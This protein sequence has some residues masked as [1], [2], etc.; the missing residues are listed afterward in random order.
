VCRIDP[1]GH[2]AWIPIIGV[3]II[4]IGVEKGIE[5]A[6]GAYMCARSL[7][8]LWEW[9]R[10]YQNLFP[11]DT[12]KRTKY[13]RETAAWQNMMEYCPQVCIDSYTGPLDPERL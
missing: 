6:I 13:L 8:E 2:F 12:A 1:D 4:G 9:A 10:Y 3:V 5:S 11:D 7:N